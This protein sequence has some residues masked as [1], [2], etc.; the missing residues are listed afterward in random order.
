MT[1]FKKKKVTLIIVSYSE[2]QLQHLITSVEKQ[3][4]INKVDD[5]K[6]LV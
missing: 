3:N 1:V 2:F 6:Y 4:K 5:V